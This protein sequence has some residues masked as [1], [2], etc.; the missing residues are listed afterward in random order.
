VVEGIWRAKTRLKPGRADCDRQLVVRTN[1]VR[2]A[3]KKHRTKRVESHTQK[4]P[5]V[6]G[7]KCLERGTRIQVLNWQYRGSTT[8]RG[9]VRIR[10]NGAGKC[11]HDKKRGKVR[12]VKGSYKPVL[13]GSK[14]G[15]VQT[16]GLNSNKGRST[17]K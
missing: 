16:G 7:G 11:D 14:N 10:W 1:N 9:E 13:W 12:M 17:D 4:S 6:A 3:R 2:N 8:L 5:V 15:T